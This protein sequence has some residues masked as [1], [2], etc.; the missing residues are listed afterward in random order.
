MSLYGN[1]VGMIHNYTNVGTQVIL[2]TWG[3]G[4]TGKQTI[5]IT[6]E[7]GNIGKQ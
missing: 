7:P 1:P 5:L 6:Y 4:H 2:I 3:P